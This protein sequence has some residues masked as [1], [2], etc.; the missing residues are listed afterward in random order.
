MMRRAAALSSLVQAKLNSSCSF[1]TGPS[2]AASKRLRWV[3]MVRRVARLRKRRF[4]VLR[5]FFLALLVCGIYPVSGLCERI[6][7]QFTDYNASARAGKG[8][9]M[10]TEAALLRQIRDDPDDVAPRLVLADWLM[11]QDDPARQARG[12]L[13]RT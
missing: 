10:D 7:W 1:S 6:F 8:C 2:R 3:L 4:S 11:E 9:S 5:R 13:I 12:E